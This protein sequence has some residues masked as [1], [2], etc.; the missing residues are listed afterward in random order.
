MNNWDMFMRFIDHAS[1]TLESN[2]RKAYGLR[3][4][5]EEILSNLIRHAEPDIPNRSKVTL[6]LSYWYEE[7][8]ET[9]QAVS[10]VLQFE[11]DAKPYDPKLE[12]RSS[13][14]SI[15]DVPL[16]ERSIGGLGLFL[17]ITNVDTVTY[18][19]AGL[20]NQYQLRVLT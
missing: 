10:C 13:K 12:C 8:N 7:I 15:L 16:Q 14:P 1:L 4:A 17:V 5:G 20:R 3:L 6:W 2:P 9:R 19:R 18:S 11:D